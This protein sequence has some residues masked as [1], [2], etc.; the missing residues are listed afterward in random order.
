VHESSIALSLLSEVEDVARVASRRVKRVEIIVGALNVVDVDALVAAFKAAA[1]DLNPVMEVE[2]RREPARLRCRRC[3]H[4]W[5]MSPEDVERMV[6]GNPR[7][8]TLLHLDADSAL[9][10]IRCPVCGAGDVEALSGARI[11][12]G[13]VELA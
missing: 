13:R 4:E 11:R 12:V 9:P 3:G 2:V 7:L 8:S 1:R 10:Y 5:V 6:K